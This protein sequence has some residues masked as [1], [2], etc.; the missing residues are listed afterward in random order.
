[1]IESFEYSVVLEIYGLD[2]MLVVILVLKLWVSHMLCRIFSTLNS[3]LNMMEGSRLMESSKRIVSF[4]AWLKPMLVNER[5]RTQMMLR[6]EIEGILSFNMSWLEINWLM[7]GSI[8]RLVRMLCCIV[9]TM[10]TVLI[11][12]SFHNFVLI[13]C[14]FSS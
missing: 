1:M 8:R 5:L 11:L 7:N 13:G 14:L 3:T 6:A 4:V 9:I 2:I 10:V 12:I